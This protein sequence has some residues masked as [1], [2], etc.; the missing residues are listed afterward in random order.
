MRTHWSGLQCLTA[1]ECFGR[2]EVENER[3]RET[4]ANQTKQKSTHISLKIIT[5]Y[6][7]NS[8]YHPTK[9]QDQFQTNAVLR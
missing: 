8:K 7:F 9:R 6:V 1:T 5:V 3:E 4:V 2:Q